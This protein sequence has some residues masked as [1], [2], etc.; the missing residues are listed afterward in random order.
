MTI[1]C[2]H[3]Y[4]HKNFHFSTSDSALRKKS[5]QLISSIKALCKVYYI[6]ARKITIYHVTSCSF[7]IYVSCIDNRLYTALVFDTKSIIFIMGQ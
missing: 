7:L 3:T 4:I 1:F 5:L 6:N 2:V